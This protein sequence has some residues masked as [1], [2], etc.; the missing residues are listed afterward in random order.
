MD[1]TSTSNFNF[2]H[3]YRKK[4]IIKMSVMYIPILSFQTIMSENKDLQPNEVD[5]VIFHNPCP[6]GMT[7]ALIVDKYMEMQSKNKLSTLMDFPSTVPVIRYGVTYYP[8]NY[9]RYPPD[10]T[11]K[12]VL[13]VDF[14]YRKNK[15]LKMIEQSNKL[16]IVDHHKSAEKELDIIPDK[17]KIFD[18]TRSGAALA[19]LYFFP[20]EPMPLLIQYVEDRDIWKKALKDTDA[21]STWFSTVPM[22]FKEYS[23]YLD[24]KLLLTMIQT[25]GLIYQELNKYK[26]DQT[27]K[28]I[29][30]KF[31]KIRGNYYFVGYI[32]INDPMLKSDVGNKALDIYKYLDFSAVYSISDY[33]NSTNF[34]LRSTDNHVDVSSVAFKLGG[35]GHRNAS[36]VR[37]NRVTN[38]LPGIVYNNVLYQNIKKIYFGKI[39]ILKTFNVVYMNIS[40][41]KSELC[42]YLLQTKY[43]MKFIKNDKS[44]SVKLVPIQEC[45]AIRMIRNKGAKENTKFYLATDESIF[46][47]YPHID[48]AAVWD[49]DGF[50][51]IT[52]FH[53]VIDKITLKTYEECIKDFFETDLSNSIRYKGYHKT[54]PLNQKPIKN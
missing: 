5:F 4:L 49:Y 33:T 10:V 24:N 8:A 26:I 36:G 47:N 17:H 23:K 22:I 41:M 7:S 54:I 46:Q 50:N 16:L 20:K 34:S 45:N 37:V 44:E 15:I 2:F 14:S 13:M 19:W 30:P 53:I 35:G 9:N 11:G 29:F 42:H 32:N 3:Q 31:C 28:Y 27:C 25:K 43:I 21:F 18:M 38:T 6:D 48:I 12:N 51:K 1:P 40:V 39:D 52:T